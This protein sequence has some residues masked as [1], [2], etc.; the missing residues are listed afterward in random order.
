[1]TIVSYFLSI[2]AVATSLSP[3]VVMTSLPM[4]FWTWSTN[5]SSW[6]DITTFCVFSDELFAFFTLCLLWQENFPYPPD[7]FL[8]GLILEAVLK[9]RFYLVDRFRSTKIPI[10][11]CFLLEDVEIHL[12]VCISSTRGRN[13]V[14]SSRRYNDIA[15][16]DFLYILVLTFRPRRTC[17]SLHL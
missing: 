17:N 12:C 7:T 4:S 2:Y 13:H 11:N 8:R 16:D 3:D 1:M 6:Q 14:A 5:V 9:L 10:S 15:S